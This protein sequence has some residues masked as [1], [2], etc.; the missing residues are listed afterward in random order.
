MGLSLSPAWMVDK[1]AVK[2]FIANG[3]DWEYA[4]VSIL[5]NSI[6]GSKQK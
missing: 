5:P 2:C 1:P 4:I 3:E 6:D